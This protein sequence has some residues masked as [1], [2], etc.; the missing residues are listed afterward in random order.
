L[1]L[2][3][4]VLGGG[5]FCGTGLCRFGGS[6]C[7]ELDC[8]VLWGK[9]FGTWLYRFRGKLCGT[10]LYSFGEANFVEVDCIGLG[11]NCLE[12]VCIGLKGA[13]FIDRI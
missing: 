5:K 10:G 8:I 2:D 13:N 1:V 4:I 3:C 12:L 6:N 11:S 7:V 9:F